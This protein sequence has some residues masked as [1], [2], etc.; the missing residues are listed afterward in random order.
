MESLHDRPECADRQREADAPC[1]VAARPYVL[2]ATIM[3]SGI[4]S[5][6]GSIILITLPLIQRD[7]GASYGSLQ[8][9]SNGYT[10]F[11]SA[12]ILIGGGAGDRYGRR[13]I[14]VIGIGIFT[15]ASIACG[16]APTTEILI[17]GRIVQGIGAALMVPQ[18]LAIIAASFPRDIRGR[19]IGLWASV[20][21]L[22]T[23][24][25]PSLGGVLL[26]ATS[27]RAAFWITPPF[28]LIVLFLA[29]RYV[30][31]SRN[32]EETGALDWRGAILAALGFGLLTLGLTALSEG[33]GTAR[34]LALI[35]AG[36][37]FVILFV[38][39]ERSAH[40]A[41]MPPKLFANR[42]FAGANAMT[43]CLYG[44]LG[45][46]LFLLPFD[47]IGRR[48]LN[49]TEVG[50]TM[51]P[52]GVI[53]GLLSRPM[54]GLAE[55][56]GGRLFLT[57]GSAIAAAA[58]IWMSFNTLGYWTGVIGPLVLLAFGMSFVFSPLS[59][60]VMNSVSDNQTGTASGVNNA[61]SRIAGLFAV[62]IVGAVS[63]T[64]FA[65]GGQGLEFGQFPDAAS[66]AYAAVED[67]FVR[68]H[69]V[70]LLVA[71][72]WA[73]IAA[74]LSWFMIGPDPEE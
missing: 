17:G 60:M 58:M 52:L 6:T 68:A 9:I 34:P 3:A 40:N 45:A 65:G 30:P 13:R 16:F 59:T 54:A 47:L 10:L 74:F 8:W 67:R 62:A 38:W 61:A 46:V 37:L 49:A 69:S 27:W 23:A 18:S 20:S 39:S 72:S 44:A 56:Y 48:G 21:A 32:E 5:V 66:P 28:A 63:A 70:A 15:I 26:D 57:I 71:A 11:L 1:A 4:A 7:L 22:T 50:L 51:L 33:S 55:D 25:G 73:V 12:L 14:F 24:I 64:L 29:L 35:G 19:A 36:V 31:E 41:L 53:I 43:V 42:R 2:A